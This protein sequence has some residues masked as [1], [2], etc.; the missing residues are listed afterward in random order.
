MKKLVML[1]ALI[2]VP[3]CSFAGP[4]AVI[5]VSV[6]M[7]HIVCLNANTQVL[8]Q[9]KAS[10]QDLMDVK[11]EVKNGNNYLVKSIVPK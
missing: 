2:L 1:I 3:L 5:T 7:P 11:E 9:D 6:T 8:D 10:S 4:V